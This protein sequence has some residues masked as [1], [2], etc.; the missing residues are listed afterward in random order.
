M[1]M[2]NTAQTDLLSLLIENTA[3]ANVGDAGGLQPSATA[4]SLYVSLHTSTPGAAGDQT[5]NEI[6]YTTYARQGVARASGSWDISGTSPTSIANHSAITFPTMSGGA[7]GTVTYAAVGRASSASGEI[8]V[9]GALTNNVV[10]SLG[11]P[12][13]SFAAG[14]MIITLT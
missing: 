6:A 5:T 14:A 10:V 1:P 13:P 7:G 2:G 4:G 9:F 8:I 11:N 12:T 3:W